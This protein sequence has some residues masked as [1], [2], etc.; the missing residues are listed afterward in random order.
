MKLPITLIFTIVLFTFNTSIIAESKPKE[1]VK[2]IDI[3]AP[4]EVVWKVVGTEFADAYVWS[5]GLK[6]SK[7]LDTISLNGS[8]TTK[9][10]CDVEGFGKITE[11]LFEYSNDEH[12]FSYEVIDGLPGFISKSYNTWRLTSLEDGKTRVKMRLKVQTKGFLG[13]L[14]GWFVIKNAKNLIDESLE[15]L[16]FY[17]E[18]GKIHPR[19]IA[20]SV[21]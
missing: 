21:K 17:V 5:S 9:R 12:F 4:I 16:K 1:I 15:E 11:E 7:A 20:N 2:H 14:L 3:N 10:G 18:T 13:W 19:T 8:T 6:H